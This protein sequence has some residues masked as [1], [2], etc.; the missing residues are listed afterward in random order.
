MN[1][2]EE[3]Y[4]LIDDLVK[5]FDKN[6]FKKPKVGRKSVIPRQ[7]YLTLAIVR[8]QMGIKTNKQ[9]YEFVK[10]YM[11]RDFP[12]MPSYVQFNEGMKSNFGFLLLLTT[13]IKEVNKHKKADYYIVDS[14]IMPVCANAHRYNVKIDLGLAS[15]GKNLNGW[16]YGFKLHLIINQNMEIVALKFT[17]ASTNDLKVLDDKFL[18]GLK[19]WLVGDK[20]YL[21]KVKAK[22]LFKMGIILITKQRKN[23]PKLPATKFGVKLLRARAKIETTFGQLKHIY[24]LINRYARSVEGYFSQALAAIVAYSLERSPKKLVEGVY[25]E[26]LIS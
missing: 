20:G 8:Q 2:I 19:G 23:M 25:Q 3:V 10:T 6:I 5:Y 13:I 15:P 4:C 14:S 21:G 12:I 7:L 24:S 22:E 26:L 18:Q 1:N 11:K 16:H 17:N 9:L